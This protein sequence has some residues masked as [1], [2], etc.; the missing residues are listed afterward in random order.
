MP[1][2]RPQTL[3]QAQE[4]ITELEN[5]LE[6]KT[7]LLNAL[8]DLMLR[9]SR[10]GVYLEIKDEPGD[11]FAPDVLGKSLWEV[12]PEYAEFFL[13][14]IEKA[15]T[16]HELQTIEYDLPI[17]NKG[18]QSFE[19]R[20]V[21]TGQDE[22]TMVV[23]NVTTLK[24]SQLE[25]ERL[26]K[27]VIDAQ[28]QALQELAVPIIPLLDGIIVMPL[29]GAI[30]SARA[31]NIL[32][33]M[34]NGIAAH[35]AQVLIIDIT[36]VP[37]VDSAVAAHLN[38]TIQVARLKGA[39]TILTGIT[40]AVAE[41]VVDLGINWSTLETLRDLQ[42]GLLSALRRIGLRVTRYTNA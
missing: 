18:L 8:P 36:G 28:R 13:S 33:A 14:H 34:Q 26:Q 29:T 31:Q 20:L 7:S 38:K 39:H 25:H 17:Y 9:L 32:R 1:T 12:M 3:E 24:Q 27:Q 30:D 41:T 5:L 42:S 6:H 40:E 37:I 4:R 19:A 2:P 23:R 15:L 21:E 10:D 11:V 35:Q 16:T 22:V